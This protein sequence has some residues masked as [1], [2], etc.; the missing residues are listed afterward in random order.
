MRRLF[1]R[2]KEMSAKIS[3]APS[4]VETPASSVHREGIYAR[5]WGWILPVLLGGALGWFGMVCLEV[6]LNESGRSLRPVTRAADAAT[7]GQEPGTSLAT[8]LKNNPFQVTP[9][10]PETETGAVNGDGEPVVTITG[11][12]STA[13][14]RWTIP[15]YGI[16]LEDKGKQ[17]W[18]L[19][20]SSFDVYTLEK[21]TYWQAFFRKDDQLVAKDL[22][23]SSTG[24][25]SAPRTS[26]GTGPD[27]SPAGPVVGQV[28]PPVGSEPGVVPRDIINRLMENPFDELKNI[29]LRPKDDLGLQVQWINKKDSILSQLGVEKG[30]VIQTVNGITFKNM[31]DIT[32]SVNSLMNSDHFDVIVVRNGQPTSLQYVVR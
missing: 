19:V 12:L 4:T 24:V 6:V 8:F 13:L 20:G 22:V 25:A 2:L 31:N 28:Q 5:A 30:D 16:F 1:L 11:S 14:V 27:P 9:M 10:T 3:A 18:L 17:D 29:R 26:P 7:R 21:V 23:Y 15:G 32:N